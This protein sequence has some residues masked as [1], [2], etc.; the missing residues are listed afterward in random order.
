MVPS[1]ALLRVFRLRCADTCGTCFTIDVNGKQYLVTAKHVVEGQRFP[2]IVDLFRQDAWDPVNTQLVGLG[3]G[4]VDIAVLTVDRQFSPAF[5]L[6][7][8]MVGMVWGQDVPPMLLGGA[9]LS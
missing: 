3:P 2:R 9:M 4:T 8:S 1:N 7:P 5:P 6:E